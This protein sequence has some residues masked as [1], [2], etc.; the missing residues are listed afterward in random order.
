MSANDNAFGGASNALEFMKAIDGALT[1]IV[2]DFACAIKVGANGSCAEATLPDSDGF[3]GM[4]MILGAS[5]GVNV[6][7]GDDPPQLGLFW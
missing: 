7:I 1:L 6:Q 4:P 3:E 5:A 2:T